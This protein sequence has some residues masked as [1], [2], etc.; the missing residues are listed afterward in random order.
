[1]ET[2]RIARSSRPARPSDPRQHAADRNGEPAPH[3]G[4]VEP[5]VRRVLPLPHRPAADP[6]AGQSRRP[7]PSVLRDRPDGFHR[8]KRL[9]AIASDMGFNGVFSANGD[10]WRRQRPMVMAGFDPKHIRSYFPALVKVTRALRAALAA[11]RGGGR[12]DRPAGR[13]D[14]LHRRRHRRARLR[15]RHQHARIR[16]GRHP[17]PPRQDLPVA[18]QAPDGARAVLG[19]VQGPEARQAPE[20]AA[21]RGR[22]FHRAGAQPHGSGSDSCAS[23]RPT[24]SRR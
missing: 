19:M 8:T 12:D 13:P 11:R 7:S 6:R 21:S 5:R 4:A 14:A 23:S 18:F 9:S 10:A 22:R 17:D 16:R 1:M 24:S 20:G 15:R 2:R 3:G